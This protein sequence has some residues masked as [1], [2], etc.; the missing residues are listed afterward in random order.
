MEL[1]IRKIYHGV[2][3]CVPVLRTAP[4]ILVRPNFETSHSLRLPGLLI[5]PPHMDK[6]HYGRPETAPSRIRL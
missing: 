6:F 5:H 1:R 4:R 2:E 3:K